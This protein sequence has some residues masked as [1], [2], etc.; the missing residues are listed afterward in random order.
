MWNKD[1]VKGKAEQVKGIVKEKA[2]RV[3]G[4]KD[5]EADGTVDQVDGKLR[6][7]V[8]AAKRHVKETADVLKKSLNR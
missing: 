6:E 7:G 3:T 4:D 2:G 1:E 8:G 5:L